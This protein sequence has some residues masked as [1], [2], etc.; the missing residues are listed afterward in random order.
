MTLL[1]L[2]FSTHKVIPF[3]RIYSD[4]ISVRLNEKIFNLYIYIHQIVSLHNLI[5]C[6]INLSKN[7]FFELI[8]LLLISIIYILTLAGFLST[9][10]IPQLSKAGNPS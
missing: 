8:S 7:N 6:F 4:A 9:I 3:Q 2:I 1:S 10:E 5:I